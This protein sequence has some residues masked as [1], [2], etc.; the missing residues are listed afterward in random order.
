MVIDVRPVHCMKAK[1]PISVTLLGIVTD[2]RPE[3]P[4][5]APPSID[6]TLLGISVFLQPAIRVLVAVSMIALQLSRESYTVF[7][8]STDMDVRLGQ[9]EKANPPINVTLLG[10]VSDV[11][12]EQ[13]WKVLCPIDVTLL[14]IV[15]DVK[16]EQ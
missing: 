8:F 5:K 14:G 15:T 4:K 9:L 2:V 16:P 13:P 3:Q 11:R 12:A 1:L 7:P 10:I 6:V